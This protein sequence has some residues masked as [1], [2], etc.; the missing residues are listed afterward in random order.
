MLRSKHCGASEII[1]R[2]GA[3]EI[4]ERCGTS[5]IIERCGA[6]E[7]IERCGKIIDCTLRSMHR[8]SIVSSEG[9]GVGAASLRRP[10]RRF[11]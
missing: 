7:I 6:S 11:L 8:A 1:E 3:S 5:E 4:T 9:G 10:H 2:C